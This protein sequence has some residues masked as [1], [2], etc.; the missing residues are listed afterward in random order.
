MAGGQDLRYTMKEPLPEGKNP[1][2][3]SLVLNPA[4][5][6]QQHARVRVQPQPRER[7]H[8][9]LRVSGTQ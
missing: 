1:G 5:H 2:P 4:F 6:A 3:A 7:P 8:E 9:P